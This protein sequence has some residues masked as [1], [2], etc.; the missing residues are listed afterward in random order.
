[1]NQFVQLLWR[2]MMFRWRNPTYLIAKLSLNIFGGLFIG[3]TFFKAK[4]SQQGTQNKLFA[5]YMGTIVSVPTANQLQ[6]PFLNMRKVYEIRE[7]PSRMYHWSA[8]LTAQMVAEIPWNMLASSL[9]FFCWYWTVGFPSARAG[10]TYLLLGVIFPFYYTSFADAVASMV[11]SAEIAAL[12]FS[13]LFSFVLTFNGVLQP[14]SQLGWWQ[15]MYHLSPYTYVIEGLLGQA[16]GGESITC[17]TDELATLTPPSGQSCYQYMSNYISEAGGYLTNPNATSACEFCSTST[18]D[19]FLQ[20]SFNISYGHR[21][22]DIGFLC[23]YVVFNIACVYAF[24]WFFRIR[25]GSLLGS[26]RKR[27]AKK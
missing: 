2:D 18:T 23:A 12:L 5:I 20:S 27:F 11:P 22:R 6:I 15:W 14:F 10:Y 3:F 26:L 19:T 4:N 21:W 16:I 24:T 25:T 13:L 17:A 8:L 9:F 7:R 1:M